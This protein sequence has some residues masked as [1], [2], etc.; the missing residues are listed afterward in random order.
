LDDAL[1]S[2]SASIACIPFGANGCGI[3]FTTDQRGQPRPGTFTRVCDIGAYE[4][5]GIHY[6]IYLLLVIK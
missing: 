6:Q 2:S 3:R 4:V 1:L 5:Q